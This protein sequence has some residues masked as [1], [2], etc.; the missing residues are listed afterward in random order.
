MSVTRHHEQQLTGFTGGQVRASAK[1]VLVVVAFASLLALSAQI[2]LFLPGTPV[3]VTMQTAVVLLC[4][5]WLRPKLA[6]AAAA[7]YLAMGWMVELTGLRLPLFAAWRAGVSTATA[8]FLLGFLPA[9]ACVSFVSRRLPRIDF[10]R[11]A[12][13]GVFGTVIIFACGLTWLSWLTGS[14][15]TALQH[16][17]YPFALWAVV[18]IAIVAALVQLTPQHWLKS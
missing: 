2:K 6:F 17:F 1:S 5:F 4:G 14:V 3:P 9:A 8:G 18:K 11:A 7:T 16:G 15:E 10:G 12:A 13:V